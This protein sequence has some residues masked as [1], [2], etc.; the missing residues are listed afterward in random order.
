MNSAWDQICHH[1]SSVLQKGEFFQLSLLEQ[2]M[3]SHYFMSMSPI[4]SFC[5]YWTL[6]FSAQIAH[7]QNPLD[8]RR[9]DLSRE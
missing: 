1:F 2:S 8:C 5:F 7:V 4:L 9:D 3:F 6:G